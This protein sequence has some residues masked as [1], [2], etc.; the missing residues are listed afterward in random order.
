M[1]LPPGQGSV[2]RSVS[3]LLVGS[4]FRVRPHDDLQEPLHQASSAQANRQRFE[5]NERVAAAQ[6]L[7]VAMISS[8]VAMCCIVLLIVALILVSLVVYVEG[9]VVWFCFRSKPCDRPLEWWLLV[10][11]VS[12]LVNILLV[13]LCRRGGA[14]RRG[15]KWLARIQLGVN[16]LVTLAMMAAGWWLLLRCRT[17]RE[18]NPELYGFVR[19]YLIYGT[20]T[21]VLAR[22]LQLTLKSLI[23]WLARNGL[24]QDPPAPKRA[25]VAPGLV[26]L[27]GTV[28]YRPGMDPRQP[29]ECCICQEPFVEE[30]PIKQTPCGHFFHA[31]CLG[32]WLGKFASSCPLCR[33]DLDSAVDDGIERKWSDA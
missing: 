12:Y 8:V 6:L 25:G 29:H 5:R 19:F 11:L 10:K 15:E 18:T 21:W 24:L 28:P 23:V 26:H 30:A 14:G 7:S 2:A 3:Q 16:F 20:V 33:C 13:V 27:I 4:V 9:W 32:N 22:L 1:A 17:C 31:E